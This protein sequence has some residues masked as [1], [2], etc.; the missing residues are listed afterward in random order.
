MGF[1]ETAPSETGDG[2]QRG[3]LTRFCRARAAKRVLRANHEQE[4][5]QEAVV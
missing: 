4:Q 3:K 1:G 2:F 5:E